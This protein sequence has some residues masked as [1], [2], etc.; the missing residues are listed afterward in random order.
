MSKVNNEK[1]K[2]H[3]H[4]IGARGITQGFP[5]FGAFDSEVVNVLYEAD[6]KAEG[7]IRALNRKR[8]AQ[9]IVVPKCI[10]GTT[11]MQD[12]YHAGLSYNSSLYPPN[13]DVSMLYFPWE[14]YD[15]NFF[16]AARTK[17]TE[18]ISTTTLDDYFASIPEMMLPDILSIDIEGA[19]LD[20]IKSSP[21]SIKNV[22]ALV[23][24]TEFVQ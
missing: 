15:H 17:Y 8:K 1:Y 23:V 22:V 4:H 10:S 20:V 24:E 5:S 3:V 19:E 12:F 6:F 13:K 21:Q 14:D 9:V 11:G 16:E 18:N 2:F 7:E